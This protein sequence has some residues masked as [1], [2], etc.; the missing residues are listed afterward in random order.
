MTLL[1]SDPLFLKHDT[2]G[3]P[4]CPD[5]LRAI[6]ARLDQSGLA[7]RCATGSFQPLTKDAIAQLHDPS[8]AEQIKALCRQGGGQIDSDTIV[9]PESYDVALA[10]A[11]ACVAAVDAVLK[12]PEKTALCLVRPPGH[13]ATPERSMGF[14]LFN[15]VALAANHA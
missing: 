14:C 12:G 3:H 13:H 5:R 1:F 8:V 4:E 15:N 2:G 9:S 10:A 7:K 6:S 11:G